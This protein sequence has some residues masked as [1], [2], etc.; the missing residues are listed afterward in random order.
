MSATI[1][2]SSTFDAKDR[3]LEISKLGRRKLKFVEGGFAMGVEGGLCIIVG[4][5]W[6]SEQVFPSRD[7][8]RGCSS[9]VGSKEYCFEVGH[10][11]KG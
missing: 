2:N 9:G 3:T 10:F 6:E 1:A 11:E 5:G 4:G 8:G 7:V